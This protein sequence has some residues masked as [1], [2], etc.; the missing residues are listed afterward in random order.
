M[1][2]PLLDPGR[3]WGLHPLKDVPACLIS[4][5]SPKGFL[6]PRGDPEESCGGGAGVCGQKE[7]QTAGD[8]GEPWL[9]ESLESHLLGPEGHPGRAENSLMILGSYRG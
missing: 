2:L 7:G 4:C 6:Q 3:L 5:V 9:R 8:Q 1:L